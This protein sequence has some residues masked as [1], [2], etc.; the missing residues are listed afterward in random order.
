M[1]PPV[2]TPRRKWT[3]EDQARAEE[4]RAAGL[5][6]KAIGEELGWSAPSIARFLDPTAAERQRENRRRAWHRS[7]PEKNRE[8][9]REWRKANPDRKRAHCQK[10]CENH[11]QKRRESAR[12]WRESNP[13]KSREYSRRCGALRRAARRCSLHPLTSK[14]RAK[15]FALFGN[16]CAYCGGTDKLEVEHVLALTAGGLDEAANIVPACR[17]CNSSKHTKPVEAWYKSQPCFNEARWAK[18]KKHC[19]NASSGQLT[20]GMQHSSAS[21]AH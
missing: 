9:A 11:P 20:L 14:Q 16:A 2:P 6:Y 4:L 10:W 12:K 17:W 5:S 3:D 7:D 13:E 15:R 19:P 21:Q 18:I 8:R 1:S